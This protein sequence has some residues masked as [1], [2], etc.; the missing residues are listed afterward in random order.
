MDRSMSRVTSLVF[1]AHPLINHHTNKDP[2]F[3]Q[4][5]SNAP[6]PYFPM[7][8]FIPR[9]RKSRRFLPLDTQQTGRQMTAAPIHHGAAQKRI[10]HD[11]GVA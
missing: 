2:T 3:Q 10:L 4:H 11:G 5:H 6:F 7:L 1:C 9:G 8:K